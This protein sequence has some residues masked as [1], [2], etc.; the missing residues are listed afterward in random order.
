MSTL[1]QL[2]TFITDDNDETEPSHSDIPEAAR[3]NAPRAFFLNALNGAAT[4]LGDKLVSPSLVLP[5]LLAAIGAPDVLAGFLVPVRRSGALLPQLAIAG[6]IEKTRI[7]KWFWFSGSVVFGI[8]FIIMALSIGLL[9]PIAAGIAVVVLLAVASLGRGVSSV[10]YKDMLG[11]TVPKGK[12]GTLLAIRSTLGGL[13]ALIAG[14]MLRLYISDVNDVTPYLILIGIGGGLWLVGAGIVALIPEVPQEASPGRT[15]LEEARAG[16]SLL[17]TV[18]GFRQYILVRVT[19]LTVTL[20]VP[21]YSLYGRDLTGAAI[22]NLGVFVI[23]NSLAEILSSPVWGRF[24]DRSARTVIIFGSGLAT[25]TG[26]LA[27]SFPLLPSHWQTAASFGV[28]ILLLGFARAGVRLGRKTYLVDG[29][30]AAERPLY[31]A[32]S[33]TLLGLVM[34]A[35]SALGVVQSVVGTQWLIAGFVGTT[36]LAIVLAWRMPEAEYMVSHPPGQ[37]TQ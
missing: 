5:W 34:L 24:A 22:G 26:I 4:K 36:L 10:A 32:V 37:I 27:L 33:N 3:D 20:S 31:S 1:E 35:G 21:Y 29:M 8:M 11:K 18:P 2:Y 15:P 7:R 17:K 9:P 14:I 25:L 16:L 13:E 6:Q 28:I 12:R 19:I 23:A 30:P